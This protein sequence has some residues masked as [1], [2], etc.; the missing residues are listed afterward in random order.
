VTIHILQRSIG[1]GLIG[2]LEL[3]SY[4]PILGP[5]IFI[6]P[7]YVQSNHSNLRIPKHLYQLL[8]LFQKL[9]LFTAHLVMCEDV[10]LFL[11]NT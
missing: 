3:H 6:K 8:C 7:A 4:I 1:L 5:I 2:L 10:L 9:V 11:L